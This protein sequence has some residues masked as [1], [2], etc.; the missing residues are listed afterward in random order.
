LIGGGLTGIALAII[1]TKLEYS[2]WVLVLCWAVGAILLTWG[3][4]WQLS[5]GW[6]SNPEKVA[7]FED[8]FLSL[9]GTI[10]DGKGEV[11]D[12]GTGRGRMAVAIAKRFPEAQVIGMDTWTRLW[13]LWGQTKTGAERNAMIERVSDQ[14]TYRKGNAQ[15][16]PFREGEFRLVVSSFAFHEIHV[17]DRTVLFKEVVRVLAPGGVFLICD[18]FPKGYQVNGVPELLEKVEQLGTQDVK[19]R[20]LQEAGIDL[21]RLYHVWGIAYLSGRKGQRKKT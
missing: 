5:V 16:L 10:W 3:I 9:L 8:D 12:I 18:L 4:F 2:I 6:V 14:C 11:L 20:T 1:F 19:H 7:P 21:G 15:A 13:S 17:P